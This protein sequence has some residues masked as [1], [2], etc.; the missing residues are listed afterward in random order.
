MYANL[1]AIFYDAAAEA[2]APP[3]DETASVWA[4]RNVVLPPGASVRY[5]P[6]HNDRNPMLKEPL[7]CFSL[8]SGVQVLVLKM[9]VQSAKTTVMVVGQSFRMVER[10]CAQMY[11]T[12]TE[13]LLDV[14][15]DQKISPIHK[16]PHIQAVFATTNSR[17]SSNRREYKETKAD[18]K[19]FIEHL[20]NINH[21][22]SRTISELYVDEVSKI[23]RTLKGGENAFSEM[24]G[25]LTTSDG[26][27]FECYVSSPDIKGYCNISKLYNLGDRRQ[28]HV[29]C[30][31]CGTKQTLKWKNFHYDE[32]KHPWYVCEDCAAVI[33]EKHKAD[34]IQHGEWIPEDPARTAEG[35]RSYWSNALYAPIG[36]GLRWKTIAKRWK[37]AQGDVSELKSFVNN[38]L[39]EEWED[40]RLEKLRLHE[41]SDRAEAYPLRVAPSPVRGLILSVDTQDDRLEYSLIGWEP[42]LKAWVLDYDVIRGDPMENAV[43]ITLTDYANTPVGHEDGHHLPISAVIVDAGGHR[44]QAVYNFVRGRHVTRPI[45]IFGAKPVTAEVLGKEKRVDVR[46]N[47]QTDP[48]GVATRQVGTIRC[49]DWLTG[50]LKN[51]A[52][53]PPEDRR[54]HFSEQL[55][56][57]YFAGLVTEFYRPETGRYEKKKGEDKDGNYRNEPLD[58]FVYNYAATHHEGLMWHK[59]GMERWPV[60]IEIGKKPERKQIWIPD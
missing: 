34:M 32:H 43:W 11:L 42:G 23:M 56:P 8:R 57:A 27:S 41:L 2:F 14:L 5:G 18:G 24:K 13:G 1:D 37:D 20:A 39:A 15:I 60:P 9:P 16:S 6:W 47:G 4:E 33:E 55:P 38:I 26:D 48:Q 21:V 17:T 22:T 31:H 25:R 46:W 50:A 36:L 49:K 12:A 19:L 3:T 58:L 28:Y 10:P 54:V 30:P 53:C 59:Q 45:A 29:P 52:E 40:P 35:Y 7:D 44:T 51:S